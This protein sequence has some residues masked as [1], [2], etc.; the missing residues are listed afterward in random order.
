LTATGRRFGAASAGDPIV[1]EYFYCSK[2]HRW[3]PAFAPAAWPPDFRSACPVCTAP[4]L[5]PFDVTVTTARVMV[6]LTVVFILAAVAFFLLGEKAIPCGIMAAIVAALIPLAGLGIR[7]ARQK[8]KKMASVAEAMGFSFVPRLMLESLRAV[9]PFR[10][11]AQGHSQ[12]ASNGM[13][14]RVGDCD[15][16]YFEFK[17]TVGGGEHSQTITHSAVLLFDGAVGVPDF[18]LVPKT[19]LDKLVG[20]FTHNNIELEDAGEFASRCKLSGPNEAAL[21]ETFHPDLVQYLG[22][23]GRWFIQAVDQQLLLYRTPQVA[24]DRCPGLVTDALEI[25]D[26]L[27]GAGQRSN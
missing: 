24:P 5:G 19:F 25:R 17:Y 16:L 26:L 10:L 9:A 21:R 27:R 23:D 7:A 1:A 3:T 20:L 4:P 13:Q 8:M 2:G 14:G 6:V 18:L 22:R 11:F 12:K 15:V